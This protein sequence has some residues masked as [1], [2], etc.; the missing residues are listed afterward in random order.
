MVYMCKCAFV[1]LD[2]VSSVP[3]QEIG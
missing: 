1:L 3:R 2:I